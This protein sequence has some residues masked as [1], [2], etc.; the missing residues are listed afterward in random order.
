[1]GSATIEL[2]APS[3][4]ELARLY[5]ELAD[6][7]VAD[8]ERMQAAR[9]DA[10]ATGN[11]LLDELEKNQA[12]PVKLDIALE[13]ELDYVVSYLAAR[14]AR[15]LSSTPRTRKRRTSL[16]LPPRSWSATAELL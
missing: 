3:T 10:V 5:S 7:L 2:P 13:A 16:R 14:A 9:D 6:K 1:M 15:A 8:V 11:R 12:A 4:A